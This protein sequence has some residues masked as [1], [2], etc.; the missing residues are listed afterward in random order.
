MVSPTAP[1]HSGGVTLATPFQG[2]Q[3]PREGLLFPELSEDTVGSDAPFRVSQPGVGFR[4]RVPGD[5]FTGPFQAA[6]TSG[7]H[8]FFPG[9]NRLPFV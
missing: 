5:V 1:P 2:V 7:F 6:W 4:T 3:A 8:H 9:Q